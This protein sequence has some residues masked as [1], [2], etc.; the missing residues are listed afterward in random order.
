MKLDLLS[1]GPAAEYEPKC[2]QFGSI[3]LVSLIGDRWML[4]MHKLRCTWIHPPILGQL[5]GLLCFSPGVR[6]NRT[7]LTVSSEFCN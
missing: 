1:L 3:S 5:I 2:V 7:E 4:F 6:S